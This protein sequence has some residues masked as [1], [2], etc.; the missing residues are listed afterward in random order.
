MNQKD[1]IMYSEDHFD[2]IASDIQLLIDEYVVG[3]KPFINDNFT[4][5][6]ESCTGMTEKELEESEKKIAKSESIGYADEEGSEEEK[7]E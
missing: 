2:D 3:S 5:L 1:Y 6:M 7:Y 4:K